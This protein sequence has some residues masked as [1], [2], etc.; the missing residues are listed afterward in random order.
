VHLESTD[1]GSDLSVCDTFTSVSVIQTV[2]S[3]S[4]SQVLEPNSAPVVY[5]IDYVHLDH[6]SYLERGRFERTY[7][8][9]V[10]AGPKFV[11]PSEQVEFKG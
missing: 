6:L 1:Y 5:K 2:C 8:L 4:L 10:S 3:Q 11:V 7:H 9:L